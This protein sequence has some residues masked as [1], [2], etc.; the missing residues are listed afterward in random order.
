MH[1]LIVGAGEVGFH[2]ARILSQENHDVAMIEPVAE[3]CQRAMDSLDVLAVE[4]SGTSVQAL[5]RAG[6]RDAEL[7]IAVSGIDE[8]NIVSCLLATKLGVP[9]KIARVRNP[10]FFAENPVLRPAELGIDLLI[11]P[12]AETAEEIYWLI[13]RSTATDVVEFANGAIELVGIKLDRNAPILDRTLQEVSQ[14][15]PS[16][17]F[18]TVAIVRE[19]RT[20]IPTGEDAFRRGDQIFVV[21]KKESVGEVLELCGKGSERM[22]R[23]MILGGGKIGRLVATLLEQEKGLDIRLIE[24]SRQK[25]QM[26]AEQLKRTLVIHGDGTNVDLLAAEGL[27]DMD[28]YIAVT[29]DEET[30]IITCLLAKHLGVRRTIA[31][32]HRADYLP[33][34]PVIGLDAAVDKRMI[35]ANAIARFVHRG[36]VVSMA[37]LR[38]NDAVALELVAKPGSKV[39][40]RPLRQIKFPKGAIIGAVSR[41]GEVFVPVGESTLSANDKAVAFALPE[42][43]S[44]VEEMFT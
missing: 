17:H 25:S 38:G 3:K 24:A 26:I 44:A 1:I 2:L 11:N 8:I 7:M 32:L 21:S 16:L 35:T 39:V 29:E 43:V 36:E 42:A 34:M 6:V 22:E 28:G 41:N 27:I 10:D 33:L 13:K 30:N 14:S 12:E 5:E 9:R 15:I 4:G 19:G 23:V 31:L 18:R 40:G 37:S 20:I